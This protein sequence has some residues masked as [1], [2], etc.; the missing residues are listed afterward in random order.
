[1]ANKLYDDFTEVQADVLRQLVGDVA[2][3]ALAVTNLVATVNPLAVS[4]P[5]A[6]NLMTVLRAF[7]G[8]W[9]AREPPSVGLWLRHFDRESG[10]SDPPKPEPPPD[11]GG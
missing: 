9:D 5:Q 8:R 2:T 6:R 1:M 10:H 3:V 11:G 4:S 7:C